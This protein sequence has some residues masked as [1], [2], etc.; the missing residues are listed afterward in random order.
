[1]GGSDSSGLQECLD[2]WRAGDPAARDALLRNSYE[3]LR[4]LTRR[5]LRGHYPGVRRWEETDDVLQ[6]VMVGLHKML[7]SVEVETV[8]DYLRLAATHINRRLIDL[9]RYYAG[10]THPVPNYVSPPPEGDP[11]GVRAGRADGE[12]D[13]SEGPGGLEAWA[14]FHHQVTLLPDEERDVFGLLWYGGLTQAEA[15]RLLGVSHSTIKRR[16]LR[17]RL[18]IAEALGGEMP[19]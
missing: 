18:R 19:S 3:R 7:D 15:A 10:K 14:E 2:R 17:A 16:W 5:M 1:M 13:P 11:S 4:L 8:L 6:R 9:A 12:A